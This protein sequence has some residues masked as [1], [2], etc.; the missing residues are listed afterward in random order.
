MAEAL[1]TIMCQCSVQRDSE[2]SFDDC[3]LN[4][5]EIKLG[6]ILNAY[7]QSPNTEKVYNTFGLEFGRDA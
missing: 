3:F 5:L 6:S 2:N 1:A 4:D 7:V